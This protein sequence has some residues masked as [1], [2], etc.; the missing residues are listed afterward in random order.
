MVT[1]LFI[2]APFANIL[3]EFLRAYTP[4]ENKFNYFSR[5]QSAKAHLRDQRR[6]SKSAQEKLL[7][8]EAVESL[9]SDQD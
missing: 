9:E 2:E 3:N 7:E 6:N 4:V 5:S 8:E 1:Y